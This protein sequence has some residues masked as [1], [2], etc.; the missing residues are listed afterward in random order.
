MTADM[1]YGHLRAA[2]ALA[3]LSTDPVIFMEND[4]ATPDSER[5]LWKRFRLSY[6]WVS[7]VQS[8]PLIGSWLFGMMNKL[9]DIPHLYPL[10]DMS[11]PTFQVNIL[12][13]YIKQG[14]C[15]GVME[16]IKDPERPAITTFYAPALSAAH[17]GR[18]N[19]YCV[20]TD[21]DFNRAWVPG[22]PAHG[23]IQYL[24]PTGRAYKRC[25]TYG[26]PRENIHL[27]G[28][29]LPP[30]L[31]GGRDMKVLHQDLGARISRLDTTGRFTESCRPAMERVLGKENVKKPALGKQPITIT[32][33]V[34]G[35]GAQKEIGN[36]IMKGLEQ[37]IRDGR[38]ILNLISGIRPE[39]NN[40]FSRK[41]RNRNLK[42]PQV[43]IQYS[44]NRKEYISEFNR[45]MKT[46]DIL[47]TKPSEMSFF[48]GLGIPIIMAPPI[49]AQEEKNRRWLLEVQAAIDQEDPASTSQ[50]LF[51]MLDHGFFAGA[52][53]MGFNRVKHDGTFAI[54]DL[55]NG[56]KIDTRSWS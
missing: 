10:K 27:T 18:D 54:E 41:A 3:H 28:F 14:L 2:Y 30:E 1:G 15:A 16:K 51:D 35:A 36:Q 46:T 31:L 33:A 32:F 5:S 34:G 37:E 9:L 6:E 17:H 40:Y 43:N 52:A 11:S 19:I 24:V 44:F 8:F 38:V 21:S 55:I 29:P 49:G 47:W 25:V 22:D 26:V 39:V 48:A 45:I 13:R 20:I 42:P 56:K 12:H 4:P 7:R 53:W 50:W 23:S